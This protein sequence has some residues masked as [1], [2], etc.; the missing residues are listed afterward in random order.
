MVGILIKEIDPEI[1][2]RFTKHIG[3]ILRM[4]HLR[5]VKKY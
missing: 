4:A 1:Q 5:R 3:G 2:E